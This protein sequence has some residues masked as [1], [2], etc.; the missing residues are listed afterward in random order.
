MVHTYTDI[1]AIRKQQH[2]AAYRQ[3][4]KQAKYVVTEVLVQEAQCER[5]QERVAAHWEHVR[6][7]EGKFYG[8]KYYFA[9]FLPNTLPFF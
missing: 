5:I 7:L 2:E 4:R 9:V 3:Q 6:E 8:S 1:R